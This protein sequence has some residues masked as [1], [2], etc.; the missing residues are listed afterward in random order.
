MVQQRG[1]YA[2]RSVNRF[3][4][5]DPAAVAA[6]ATPM[7]TY[8]DFDS[9]SELVICAGHVEHDGAVVLIRPAAYVAAPLPARLVSSRADHAD[10]EQF[11]REYTETLTPVK[12]K[13]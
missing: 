2:G 5:F 8:L 4:V 3:R 1:S 11:V 7:R 13:A 10:D 6:R 12:H 9:H